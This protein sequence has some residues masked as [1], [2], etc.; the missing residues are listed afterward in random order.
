[1]DEN[2]RNI[3][4]SL[5]HSSSIVAG[6]DGCVV[7]AFQRASLLAFLDANPGVLLSLIG[8]QVVV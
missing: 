5:S 1:M 8:R 7:Y 6:G 2:S 3:N 4:D